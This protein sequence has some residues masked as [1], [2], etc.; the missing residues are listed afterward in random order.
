MGVHAPTG[1]AVTPS[2]PLARPTTALSS[3]L[4]ILLLAM[5]VAALRYPSLTTDFARFLAAV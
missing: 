3:C 2:Q 5:P 4:F 1:P